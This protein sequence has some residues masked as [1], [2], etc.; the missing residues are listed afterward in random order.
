MPYDVERYFALADCGVLARDDRVE[1]LEGLIVAM[2]PQAPM[3]AAIVGQVEKDSPRFPIWMSKPP[4][5][6][7]TIDS[8]TP[9]V[10]I[11]RGPWITRQ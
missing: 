7:S 8:P 2:P 11:R 10:G 9:G 4:S 5:C 6:F 3:H 1:L